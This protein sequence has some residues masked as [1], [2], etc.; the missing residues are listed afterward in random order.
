MHARQIY[1]ILMIYMLY[2][3]IGDY[4]EVACGYASTGNFLTLEFT[5]DGTTTSTGFRAKCMAEK[6]PI[7]LVGM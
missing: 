7:Q 5:T 6:R 4:G 2:V 3:Y 1:H